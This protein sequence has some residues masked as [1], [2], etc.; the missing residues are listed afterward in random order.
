MSR[1]LRALAHSQQKWCLDD[2]DG[3]YDIRWEQRKK[4]RKARREVDR[5]EAKTQ[6]A[7]RGGRYP[8]IEEAEVWDWL[9]CTCEMCGGLDE[10]R[11]KWLDQNTKTLPWPTRLPGRVYTWQVRGYP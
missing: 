9:D 7:E 2:D 11:S 4:T 5:T 6:L 3:Y 10:E 1:H 8:T